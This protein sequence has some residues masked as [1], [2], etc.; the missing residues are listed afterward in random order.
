MTNDEQYKADV[1]MVKQAIIATDNLE[2]IKSMARGLED[3]YPMNGVPNQILLIILRKILTPDEDGYS[4]WISLNELTE[5]AMSFK[6]RNGQQWCRSGVDGYVIEK[7]YVNGAAAKFR[8]GGFI[9]QET[10]RTIP[11]SIKTWY[12]T[13]NPKCAI[14]DV[15]S[16]NEIDHK[17]GTYENTVDVN[18]LTMDDFQPLSKSANDAKRQHCK[19]CKDTGKIATEYCKNTETKIYTNRP[20]REQ[21]PN[22]ST[23]AGDKY[24]VPTATC[25]KHTKPV[26]EQIKVPNVIGK[27]ETEAKSMLSKFSIQLVY[28]ENTT[29]E[30]GIVLRQSL[31]EGTVV[32]VGTSIVIFI[33]KKVTTEPTP[34]EPEE[35][36]EPNPNPNPNPNVNRVRE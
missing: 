30:N 23:S 8:L 5:Y 35:P 3:K 33:N 22:W 11:T 29:A 31:Q 16:N 19:I 7:E 24:N 4:D 20:E 10:N 12:K 6:T 27:T 13:N 36:D 17:D 28:E 1:K 26:V 15:H 34:E 9:K 14:L 2:M 21:N 18:K 32:D 25:D